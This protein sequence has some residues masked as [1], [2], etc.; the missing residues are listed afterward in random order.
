MFKLKASG[1]ILPLLACVIYMQLMLT[2]LCTCGSIGGRREE[3]TLHSDGGYDFLIAIHKDVN[4]DLELITK[5]QVCSL[6]KK[7][8]TVDSSA[9]LILLLSKFSSLHS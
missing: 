9:N 6:G 2:S 1:G 3:I 8:I 7:I 5:L 4:E